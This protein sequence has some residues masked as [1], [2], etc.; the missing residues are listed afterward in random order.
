[1]IE[2]VNNVLLD[3]VERM[4]FKGD[5]S[6]FAKRLGD[7]D[8]TDLW[9][10]LKART[11][12][13][14]R[15]LEEWIAYNETL[16]KHLRVIQPGDYWDRRLRAA[17]AGEDWKEEPRIEKQATRSYVAK[18]RGEL[19]ALPDDV[20]WLLIKFWF[21]VEVGD[22]DQSIR[23]GLLK[24]TRLIADGEITPADGIPTDDDGF[25]VWLCG[26]VEPIYDNMTAK[27]FFHTGRNDDGDE[28]TVYGDGG[29]TFGDLNDTQ[30]MVFMFDD[31]WRFRK[32]DIE[33]ELR[34]IIL[35]RD[36]GQTLYEL[37]KEK[38]RI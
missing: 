26:I 27:G 31:D 4:G 22:A 14:V 9:R 1:M 16:P 23:D 17:M 8:Y 2:K 29:G 5:E 21:Y 19:T 35:D 34:H 3:M 38:G 32:L 28:V 36:T 12:F 20:V 30:Q 33:D 18:A 13:K 24:L 15:M 25:E 11:R 7:L 6:G 37:F 10:L